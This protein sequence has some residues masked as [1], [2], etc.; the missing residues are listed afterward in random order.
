MGGLRWQEMARYMAEQG[1]GVDV[2]ARDFSDVEQ[3]DPTRLMRLHRGV[4]IFSVRVREPVISQLQ[5]FAWKQIKALLPARKRAKPDALSQNEV[6]ERQ[7]PRAMVRSYHARMEFVRGQIWARTAARLSAGI[8]RDVSFRA[9]ITSGPPHMAHEAGRLASKRLRIP[10]IVD[11]RDPWSLVQRLREEI[12]SPI[13]VRRA[14]SFETRIINSAA[15]V[16]MNTQAARDAMRGAYKE[17]RDKIT[18]IRNGSDDEPL[19]PPVRDECFRLRFAGAIYMDRDP[20][21]VFKAAKVVI[22]RLGLTPE[23]F[24]LEFVG[25]ANVFS[26]TP[27]SVIAEQEGVAPFVKIG[28]QMPRHRVM[29]FLAGASMLLSL[30]QDSDYAVPAKIFEYVRFHAWMLVLATPTS[31]TAEVLRHS[32]ADVVDP[33]DIESMT[34]ILVLRYQEF[35]KGIMPQP[36]GRDGRFDRWLQTEKLIEY[37]ESCSATARLTE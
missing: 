6:F 20:R 27:T 3:M 22:D 15:L 4:R 16:T 32:D 35:S 29:E 14:R 37:I 28:S 2:V 17:F 36:A 19:P 25:H 24:L 31:A 21:P 33:T 23:K 26:N 13:W 1:W 34:E 11:M 10:H 8:A 5:K 12:A 18:V 30:P 9:V 7:G